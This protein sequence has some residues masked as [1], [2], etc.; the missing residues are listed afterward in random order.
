MLGLFALK[1]QPPETVAAVDLG[2]N[3][4]H[5]IVARI[6]DGQVNILDR[7][8]E[9]VRLADGLD[10]NRNLL[11]EAQARALACLERFGQR[12]REMPRGSVRIVGTNTLRSAHNSREFVRA[13]EQALGHGI[14]IIAGREEARLI[15]LGV[16]HTMPGN[17][18]RRLVMDIG[19]GSTEFIVGE[20]F[21]TLRRESLYMGCVTMTKRFFPDNEIKPKYLRRAEIAARLELQP[22]AAEF[23]EAGWEQAVGASG[24]IK[25][26]NRV[27]RAEGWSEQDITP[28]ALQKLRAALLEAGEF[29]KLT[30]L[31]GL[32]EERAPVFAGGVAI[33]LGAFEELGIRQMQVS[34]GAL[35]EGL[36]YDLLGRIM[37][38]DVRERTIQALLSRYG[39][40]LEQARRVATTALA[41]LDQVAEAWQLQSEEHRY[42]L[43]WAALLHETGVVVA[44]N[45]YHK[46]GAY[47]LQNS[48]L[49]GFSR[50]EQTLLALLVR[51]HRRKFPYNEFMAQLGDKE[52][53]R[54]AG[55][56][57]I[58][59]RLAVLL[60]RSR[61]SSPLPEFMLNAQ[62]NTLCIGFSQDWL[63]QHPLSQADLEQEQIYLAAAG[64]TL[65]F[66]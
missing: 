8:R 64:F 3:S 24:T 44:H 33:L 51:A 11:P 20:H 50:Q 45:Q 41:C 27:I 12:L 1:N 59:L 26:I 18:A 30:Q 21:E 48:D 14:E 65:R 56:L 43:N 62:E 49:A 34:D 42:L 31:K 54:M 16:A 46:H 32:S 22:I 2:S 35:R 15:Y 55:Y 61:V 5:M 53:V 13:A 37:H 66:C 25:A 58:L 36:V 7:L 10:E 4:F 29:K 39:I 47:I 60:H 19:G 23:R 63:T 52:D 38:E 9:S 57:A 28:A 40:D 6:R 17:S